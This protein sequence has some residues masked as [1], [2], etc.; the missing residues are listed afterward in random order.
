M[1]TFPTIQD[2]LEARARLKPHIRHTP[3]LR[4]DKIEKVVGSH[5]HCS[6]VATRAGRRESAAG[7]DGNPL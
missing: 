5:G 6:W 7:P 2:I 1:K 3:L 4:A